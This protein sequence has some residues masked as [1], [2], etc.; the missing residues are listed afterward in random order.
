MQLLAL[1]FACWVAGAGLMTIYVNNLGRSTGDELDRL[2]KGF[3]ALDGNIVAIYQ[4][5][6]A[7]LKRI[8]KLELAAQATQKALDEHL[9]WV[10]ARQREHEKA[11]ERAR[12]A[13]RGR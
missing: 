6:G 1:A 12:K 11:A 3:V 9:D 10:A 5:N 13:R 7:R 4:S 8:E 2:N